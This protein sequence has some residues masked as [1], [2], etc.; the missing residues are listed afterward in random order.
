MWIHTT[1]GESLNDRYVRRI[2]PSVAEDKEHGGY[3][4]QIVA[5]LNNG[6][7]HTLV[8]NKERL[9]GDEAFAL[10]EAND[11]YKRFKEEF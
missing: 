7:I 3:Y 5:E 9:L 6:E 2:F 10:S 1:E 11:L 4:G 8:T